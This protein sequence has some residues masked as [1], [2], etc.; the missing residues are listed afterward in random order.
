LQER[1]GLKPIR[2]EKLRINTS[3]SAS[4]CDII[5]ICI[6]S[7]NGGETLYI[8]AYTSPVICSP[9][10]R[11]VDASI[12]EHLEGLQLADASDSAQRIDVL[13]G[14]DHY[15]SVVTGETIV[16][17]TGPVA[18]SS[19]LG[20]LL[21]GTSDSSGTVNLTHSNVIVNC[22]TANVLG[23]CE[24]DDIVKALRCFWDTE[25]IGVVG[26]SQNQVAFLERLQFNNSRYEVHL[27]WRDYGLEVPDHFNLCLNRLR[28]LHARLLKSP[29]LLEKYHTIIQDQLKKGIVEM[30]SED[31]QDLNTPVHYLP[32]HGV[33]RHDK[34]TSK[35]RIVY[36]GLAKTETDPL[37]L[38][39]CLKTGPNMIPKLFDV[40]VTFRWQA[41]A[42]TADIKQAFLMISIAPQDREVL[43]FLWFK[44]PHDTDSEIVKLR[45]ARLVFGLRPSPAVLGSV[46]SHHLD[47]YQGQ[48]R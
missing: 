6:Q 34:R 18:V 30:V 27:P 24:D 9:L 33:L 12:Y 3:F 7:T 10:P 29:E 11:L 14:S 16:G 2:R 21:S 28:L 42:V 48:L 26:D 40:L 36:D 39:D 43:R 38:N 32:H 5:K 23:V 45:F 22:D 8:T 15:W 19:R 41:V 17:E 4:P 37:S 46:I 25:S 47:K 20:W 1:L 35:L 31:P 44:N 13:I